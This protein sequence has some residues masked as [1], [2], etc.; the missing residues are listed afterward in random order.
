MTS[1]EELEQRLARQITALPP[2]V[3]M[4]LLGVFKLDM[5]ERASRMGQLYEDAGTGALAEV[6]IDLESDRTARA[7][8]LGILIED[9]LPDAERCP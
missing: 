9:A 5:A 2:P 1:L 4:E 6:L 7:L 3:R 8:V